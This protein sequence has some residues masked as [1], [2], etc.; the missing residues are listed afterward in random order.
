MPAKRSAAAVAGD[1]SEDEINVHKVVETKK[2]LDKVPL[3]LWYCTYSR[4]WSLFLTPY[5]ILMLDLQ[6]P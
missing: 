3:L 4:I 2:G 6:G 1:T 5:P